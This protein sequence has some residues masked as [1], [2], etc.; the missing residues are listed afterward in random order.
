MV[1]VDG[2]AQNLKRIE[3]EIALA[4]TRAGRQA[5]EI[6]LVGVS[7]TQPARAVAEAVMAGLRHIG[8][9]RVQEAVAKFGRLD[10]LLGDS[11]RPIRHLVGHLQT[12]K[13]A[14]AIDLFER[15]DSVDSLK[16]AQALGRRV[17]LGRELAVLLEIY[18]GDDPARP[19][20]R[21]EGLV[22]AVGAIVEV[23]GIRVEGLMT[24]A[25]LGGD[26]R[27]AFRQVAALKQMLAAA[28]PRVHFGHLSMGMSE[29]FSIAIEAGATEV[30]VGTALFGPRKPRP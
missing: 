12:N 13:A 24:V 23:P 29:D 3:E 4:A 9:N 1:V 17:P 10:E 25:P 15:I 26:P 18:V 20:L 16:L 28:F 27:A 14:E 11:A 7:K 8:E 19:G 22:E 2:I 5:E 21:V 6:T 30:R